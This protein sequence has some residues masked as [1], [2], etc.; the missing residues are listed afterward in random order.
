[1]KINGYGN[2][3]D[4]IRAYND[5]KKSTESKGKGSAAI[6][7]GKDTLELSVRAQE[8]KEIKLSMDNINEIRDEKISQIKKAIENGEY[9]IDARKIA[10]GIIQERLLDR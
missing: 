2:V 8:M 9:R 3:P 5:Q 7:K 4:L 10:D 1:M 6:D